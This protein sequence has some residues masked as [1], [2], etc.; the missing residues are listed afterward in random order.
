MRT[1]KRRV[2]FS[3]CPLQPLVPSCGDD[4]SIRS[5]L[6]SKE[7]FDPILFLGA[8]LDCGMYESLPLRWAAAGVRVLSLGG[9]TE[10]V[11]SASM[12]AGH[13]L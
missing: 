13:S 11:V 10:E 7:P 1:G 8:H 6:Q 9:N 4:T 12:V 2:R 5:D 3:G